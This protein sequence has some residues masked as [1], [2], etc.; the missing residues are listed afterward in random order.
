MNT[1]SSQIDTSSGAGATVALL[2][3]LVLGA[4]GWGGWA[5]WDHRRAERAANEA[6]DHV[7]PITT[8]TRPFTSADL[9]PVNPFDLHVEHAMRQSDGSWRILLS[10]R[11]E[12]E[13]TLDVVQLNNVRLAESTDECLVFEPDGPV[14]TNTFDLVVQTPPLPEELDV[15]HLTYDLLVERATKGSRA[16]STT[17]G[18]LEATLGLQ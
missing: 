3:F 18:S 12:G 1:R 14:L 4:C 13:G 6:F 16:T 9:V 15:A 5:Y 10:C 2:V 7:A 11:F 8:A 17:T